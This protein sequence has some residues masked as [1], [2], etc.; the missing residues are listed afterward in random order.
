MLPASLLRIHT[1]PQ[2]PG[3]CLWLLLLPFW[4]PPSNPTNLLSSFRRFGGLCAGREDNAIF[5]DSISVFTGLLS[6]LLSSIPA[7]A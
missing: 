2:P 1:Q 3:L 7:L 4:A 6:Y 5:H